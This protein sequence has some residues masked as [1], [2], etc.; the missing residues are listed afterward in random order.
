MKNYIS[1]LVLWTIS[2]LFSLVIFHNNG[3]PGRVNEPVLNVLKSQYAINPQREKCFAPAKRL[4]LAECLMGKENIIPE[5]AVWGDSHSDSMFEGLDVAFVKMNSSAVYY[6]L[7]AC[8]PAI[9]EGQSSELQRCREF[10]ALALQRIEYL[11]FKSVILISKW[12]SDYYRNHNFDF[13][14]MACKLHQKGLHVS[15]ILSVPKFEYNLPRYMAYKM[16][17]KGI[18]INNFN[19]VEMQAAQQFNKINQEKLLFGNSDC[20]DDFVD[21]T[22]VYCNGDSCSPI[23][24]GILMYYDD[25]HMNSFGSRLFGDYVLQKYPNLLI[26]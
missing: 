26:N 24:N 19:E 25:N 22:P 23:V 12:S 6:G 5:I 9:I 4:I 18:Q 13:E 17:Q 11:N 10:N 16:H 15:V 21:P 2:I 3:F 14:S 1:M 20:V 8:S 7:S